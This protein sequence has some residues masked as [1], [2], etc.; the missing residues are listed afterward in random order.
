MS[1]C[2]SCEKKNIPLTLQQGYQFNQNQVKILSNGKKGKPGK[3]KTN[4]NKILLNEIYSA[5]REDYREIGYPNVGVGLLEKIN[6]YELIDGSSTFRENFQNNDSTGIDPSVLTQPLPSK[7]EVVQNYFSELDSLDAQFNSV[8]EQYNSS[9]SGYTNELNKYIQKANDKSSLQNKNIS[10][11]DGKQYYVNSQNVAKAFSSDTAYSN[12]QSKNNCPSGITNI[13]VNTLPTNLTVGAN[14]NAGQSCGNEGM[15]V[16]VN[17][18]IGSPETAYIGCYNDSSSAPTMTALSNGNTI[19]DYESCMKVA[20]DNNSP[21]FALENMNPS[22]GLAKCNLGSSLSSIQQYGVAYNVESNSVWTSGTQETGPN[23]MIMK[24]D[25]NFVVQNNSTQ[26]V[27]WSSNSPVSGCESGGMIQPNSFSGTYGM[28]CYSKGYNV[29]ANNASDVLNKSFGSSQKSSWSLGIN[30]SVYGDPAPGCG[31][32]FN[33]S[34]SCGENVIKTVTGNE[35]GTAVF[36]C[37]TTAATCVFYMLLNDNGNLCLFQGTPGSTG[38]NSYWCS[39]SITGNTSANP[40]WT[41]QKGKYGVNYIKSGQSLSLGE[42]I[43]SPSGTAKLMMDTDGALRIFVSTISKTPN[44]YKTKRGKMLGNS[45][46]NA[47]YSLVNNGVISNVGKVG[48]I[49]SNS[50]VQ[51]YPNTMF[52]YGSNYD[53]VNGFDSLGNTL[54]NGV[55]A[56]TTVSECQTKCNANENCA[57]FVFDTTSN[58]GELKSAIFPNASRE[59]TGNK[60]IY[61]RKMKIENENSC[62]KKVVDIDS[63]LWNNY[64]VAA[65]LMTPDT[66]CILSQELEDSQNKV[67]QLKEQMNDISMKIMN[68]VNKMTKMNVDINKN[69]TVNNK[70]LDDYIQKYK[71]ASSQIKTDLAVDVVNR[72]SILEDKN[73]YVLEENYKYMLWSTLAIAGIILT[74]NIIRSN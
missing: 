73:I 71:I 47:L 7:K 9:Q 45:N 16:Y 53:I 25:G 17:K 67:N 15:N 5:D 66:K 59:P 52:S 57:G 3:N 50:Q 42:W 1:K 2:G 49:N 63:V 6:F 36:D 4:C 18:V 51:E 23:T 37:N 54:E 8:L 30:N 41:S 43:G 32:D 12:T 35:G 19:Y 60:N 31:K 56:N 38:A 44:C 24:N 29:V 20:A 72:N 68:I 70:S 10:L 22:S 40:D 46:S 65:N 74:M 11:S 13:G 64:P 33:A 14:M 69:M 55:F 34:Y 39:N 26:E 21:Y 61:S 48:Y 62:S 27:V 28:N 58:V